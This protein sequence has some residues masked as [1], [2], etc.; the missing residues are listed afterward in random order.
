[1][2]SVSRTGGHAPPRSARL[3]AAADGIDLL[4]TGTYEVHDTA[5]AVV[6]R[7]IDVQT[8]AVLASASSTL[9]RARVNDRDLRPTHSSEIHG[10][11]ERVEA[12]SPVLHLQAWTSRGDDYL[13]LEEGERLLL[14]VRV[15][16]PCY[17]RALLRLPT[18]HTAVLHPLLLNYRLG[19]TMINT[20]LTL[21]DTLVVCPPFGREYLDIAVSPR[22]FD[23]PHLETH[24][25]DG[26]WY[27]CIAREKDTRGRRARGLRAERQA[28]HDTRT[29][30]ETITIVSI[31]ARGGYPRTR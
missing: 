4:L 7:L 20:V 29:V 9:E 10:G 27:A 13:V 17:L 5:V 1:V 11:V 14:H 15:N 26:E 18:G 12:R 6:A 8:A 16:R 23:K 31:P 30:E 25:F 28:E 2:L 19:P 21:P 22:P 24:R 3:I